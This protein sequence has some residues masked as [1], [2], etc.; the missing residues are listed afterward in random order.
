MGDWPQPTLVAPDAATIH[1]G[2]LEAA[3]AGFGE[4]SVVN[5]A[6][7]AWPAAN[8]AIYVP[9]VLDRQAVAAQMFWENGAVAGT[10]D[11]GIYDEQGTRLV[12]LGATT[13]AGTVQLGNIADT[14]LPP[15]VYYMAG[16]ASTATTQTYWSG[17]IGVPMLRAAGVRSQA[18]GAAALPATATFAAMANGY[19]PFVGVAFQS[20]V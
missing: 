7:A 10:T 20:V 11:V 14:T 17:A 5:F 4:F 19:L 2:A 1:T 15:G 13:N 8:L 12:S 16:L 9:F 6:A 3:T 18:V